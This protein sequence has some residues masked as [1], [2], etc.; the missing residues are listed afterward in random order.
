MMVGSEAS[1]GAEGGG[2]GFGEVVEVLPGEGQRGAELEGVAVRA[3]GADQDAALA[4][5]VDDTD[6]GVAV[7]LAGTG[8]GEVGRGVQA[9]PAHGADPGRVPR[10]RL[11]RVAQVAA[12]GQGVFPQTLGLDHVQDRGGGGDADRVAAERVEV[13]DLVA[14]LLEDLRAGG[15]PPCRFMSAIASRTRPAK[16]SP[17]SCGSGGATGQTARPSGTAGPRLVEI[18]AAAAVRAG[19]GWEPAPRSRA[20]PGRS[21]A[22]PSTVAP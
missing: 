4:Q 6:R 12:H 21:A 17:W 3:G 8:L 14:E 22:G 18:S 15:H 9:G 5:A 7:G 13:P 1:E 16:A 10:D 2:E 20:R 19:G 11:Q